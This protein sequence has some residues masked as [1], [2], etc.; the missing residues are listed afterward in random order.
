[1][2]E[3]E[4][5]I[6]LAVD[7]D[8]SLHMRLVKVQRII[9]GIEELDLGAKGGGG[10]LR[11]VLS[12]GFDLVERHPRLLPGEL[13]FAAL[14]E[15]EAHNLDAVTLFGV[16]RDRAAGAP[17]KI[18]GVRRDHQTRFSHDFPFAFSIFLRIEPMSARRQRQSSARWNLRLAVRS[19]R[20]PR[21]L[22]RIPG[23]YLGALFNGPVCLLG[24]R[25]T[26]AEVTAA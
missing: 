25:E 8:Q 23:T 20:P 26:W 18:A 3:H 11:L 15:G 22:Q 14:A 2:G 6:E 5:R 4:A 10:A 17:D 16:Q 19:E 13:G 9:A 7:V 21:R 12:P 1:M 24:F